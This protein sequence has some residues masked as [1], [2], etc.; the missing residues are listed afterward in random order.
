LWREPGTTVDGSP[1]DRTY[2][3]TTTAVDSQGGFTMNRYMTTGELTDTILN[4]ADRNRTARIS[5]DSPSQTCT[6]TPKRE[7]FQYPMFVGKT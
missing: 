6:F 1:I 2:R 5:A 4:D 7:H 3:D